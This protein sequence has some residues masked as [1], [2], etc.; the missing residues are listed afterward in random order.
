MLDKILVAR[1]HACAPRASTSL[2][3]VGGD[4]S[5]LHVAGMAYGDGGLLVRDQV[6]ELDFGSL[7]FNLGTTLVAILLP[8]FF[9]FLHNHA[10]QLLLG[11]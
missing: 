8:D 3:A 11:S 1:L 10:A 6:F 4:R 7:V 2:H 5:A 9:E